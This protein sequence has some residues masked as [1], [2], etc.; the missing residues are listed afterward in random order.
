MSGSSICAV[1]VTYNPLEEVIENVAITI[2]QVNY[3]VIVD[4]GSA[5]QSEDYIRELEKLQNCTV[6]RNRQNL[7]I[8]V[9]L[10]RGIDYALEAG[11]DWVATFDQDSRISSGFFSIMLNSYENDPLSKEIAILAPT[12]IDTQSGVQGK[13][14]RKGNGEILMT[15]SSGSTMP[16]SIIRE[17]GRFDESLY[18]DY[19]DIDFC[20]RARQKGMRIAQSPAVLLHSLGRTTYYRFLGI[21]FSTTNHSAGRRYYIT[22]NRLRLLKRYIGNWSWVWRESKAFFSE[23][24]KVVLLEDDK[25]KKVGAIAEGTLDALNGRV[26]RKIEL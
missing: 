19:V 9:A 11:F 24:V 25:W 10:N 6:L 17:L 5:G 15:M 23:A 13:L 22:R 7:G 21:N 12:Y 20:L 3:V 18:M 4:N 16:S 2:A 14:T 26:G 1:F 8:A